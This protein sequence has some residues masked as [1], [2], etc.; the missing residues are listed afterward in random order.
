MDIKDKTGKVVRT[1]DLDTLPVD[2]RAR[3]VIKQLAADIETL[4]KRQGS[5][6]KFTRVAP[7]AKPAKKKK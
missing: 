4:K 1:I 7:A 2:W 3:A 5:T 6:P